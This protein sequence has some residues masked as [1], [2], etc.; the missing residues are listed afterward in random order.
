MYKLLVLLPLVLFFAGCGDATKGTIVELVHED[1]RHYEEWDS[2]KYTV[3]AT[4]IDMDGELETYLDCRGGY[5]TRFDDEDWYIHFEDCKVEGTVG[6]YKNGKPAWKRKCKTGW[7]EI[8][9]LVWKKT[10]VGM[11]FDGK[12]VLAN[13]PA[14]H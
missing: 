8:D 9:S 5:E 13:A 6:V 4:R 2:C 3:P 12:E 1:P 14:A 11:Y 7:K 10:K